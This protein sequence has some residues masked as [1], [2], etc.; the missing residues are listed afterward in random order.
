MKAS[1]KKDHFY[2]A[3]NFPCTN[4]LQ[5]FIFDQLGHVGYVMKSYLGCKMN[6]F[7]YLKT[8]CLKVTS[9][10]LALKITIILCLTHMIMS[11]IW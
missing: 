4:S 6:V 1:G 11:F 9:T 3:L 5:T 10:D 7:F 8:N 2:L